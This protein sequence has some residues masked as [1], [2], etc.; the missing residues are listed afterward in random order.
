MDSCP[1]KS[2][3]FCKGG[4]G[5]STESVQIYC[6]WHAI[7][8][9]MIKYRSMN[10]FCPVFKKYCSLFTKRTV[11]A[12]KLSHFRL[13]PVHIRYRVGVPTLVS[14]ISIFFLRNAPPGVCLGRGGVGNAPGARPLAE[15]SLPLPLK[16]RNWGTRHDKTNLPMG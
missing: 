15:D 10:G 13:K 9:P 2:E 8:E 12:I 5:N 6:L 4:H 3:R 16:K 11:Q 1:S 14:G 7:R